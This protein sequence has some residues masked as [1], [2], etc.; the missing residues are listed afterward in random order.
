MTVAITPPPEK[1]SVKGRGLKR[2]LILIAAACALFLGLVFLS[3]WTQTGSRLVLMLVTEVSPGRLQFN[4]VEGRLADHLRIK[5]LDYESK[6]LVVH[7]QDV[8][9]DWSISSLFSSALQIDVLKAAALQIHVT[10]DDTPA[11]LPVHLQAPFAF[12]VK[13]LMITQ[14]SLFIVE[15]AAKASPPL[16]FEKLHG[17]V[18][19][20]SDQYQAT[21]AFA[22]EWGQLSG[23][24]KLASQ[25]PFALDANVDYQNRAQEELP[26][27]HLVGHARGT[28]DHFQFSVKS[29]EEILTNNVP[30]TDAKSNS[31]QTKEM[32]ILSSAQ[33]QLALEVHLFSAH[34]LQKL[35]TH[36]R[37]FDPHLLAANAPHALLDLDLKLQQEE[38]DRLLHLSGVLQMRNAKAASLD[39]NGLP[40]S[41]LSAQLVWRNQKL[42]LTDFSAELG[43]QSSKKNGQESALGKIGGKMSADFS[44]D[45]FPQVEAHFDVRHLNLATIDSRVRHTDVEGQVQIQNQGKSRIEFQAKLQ[46]SRTRLLTRAHI[47][48]QTVG[49]GARLFLDQFELSADQSTLTG[50]AQ[51]ELN[52]THR[53]KLNGKLTHFNPAQWFALP[54]G[55]VDAELSIEGQSDPAWQLQV[56]V[57]SLSGVWQGR[58][59]EG[60]LHSQWKEA[61]SLKFEQTALHLG[62][63]HLEMQGQLGDGEDILKLHFKGNDLT[64]LTA[65]TGFPV[66]GSAEIDASLKGK[67]SAFESDLHLAAENLVFSNGRRLA[68]AQGQITLGAG[69]QGVL[70]LK[71]KLA[72]LQ[73]DLTPAATTSIS[74]ASE[75]NTAKLRTYFESAQ[76]EVGGT[77]D[78]HQIHSEIQFDRQHQ[79]SLD[80][81]G[82]ILGAA[83]QDLGWKGRVTQ[84]NLHGFL[85][86]DRQTSANAKVEPDLRLESPFE[87]NIH[88]QAV[89]MG[90]AVLQGRLGKL[91]LKQLEWTPQNLSSQGQFD[92]L[93]ALALLSLWKPQP[94]LVGDL[95]LGLT[96]DFQ[97]KEHL[98]AALNLQRQGGDIG[99]RDVDGTGKTMPLGIE[100][101]HLQL[102]SQAQTGK[103]NAERVAVDLN[104]SGQRLGTWQAHLQSEIRKGQDRWIL[105]AQT[106]IQGEMQVHLPE[107]Q[108]LASQISPEFT[109]KGSVDVNAQLGGQLF[110]P[111]Y[112][113]QIEGHRLEL[114]FAS[115]GLLFPN[116]E[117]KAALT[118]DTLSLQKLVF[119]QTITRPVEHERFKDLSWSQSQTQTQA[120]SQSQ[121]QG[122]FSASG[123][124]NWRAQSGGITAQWTQF[125]L[126]QRRDRWLVMSGQAKIAQQDKAWALTGNL[127]ADAGF[128]R[129]P[130]LPPPSLS[131]DVVIASAKTSESDEEQSVDKVGLKTRLDLTVDM[132]SRFI[133]VGRGLNTAL[134]GSLRLK[135]SDGKSVIA[136]GRIATDGGV[137]EGYGQQLSIERGILDFHGAANNPSLNIRALRKGLQVEAGVDII[138]SVANPQ[139]RLVSEPN[140]PDN[141]KISWLVF[142]RESEQNGSTDI[143]ALL[144][145]AG[146]ILGGDG[147]RE[148]SATWVR[149]LGFDSLTVGPPE[150]GLFSK[151]PSQTV[152]GAISV[153]AS[154]NENVVTGRLHVKPGL[155]LS[156]ER[157]VSDASN[158]LSLSWQWSRRLRLVG[159]K[160][161][162]NALDVRYSFS[163]N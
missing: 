145:A 107:L 69:S 41:Q 117:L 111:K 64:A 22:S 114:A 13:Q 98:R 137:Y 83:W 157:G 139:V 58:N 160:G 9:L 71:L 138:G 56:N 82:G 75:G 144:S 90:A 93:Q 123:D 97:F 60:Q 5:N 155:V 136:N 43:A 32:R 30:V 102:T 113:A 134:S 101:L 163:F 63:N 68:H 62:D 95:R 106:P 66:N 61:R 49:G 140:V 51:V 19:A 12:N 55:R 141:E 14:T 122:Q 147:S 28:L 119:T 8:Q 109:M 103:P 25:R 45:Q 100:T 59:L 116:G 53:F 158:A 105:D 143:S 50:Q 65:Q 81:V 34:V 88:R 20:S 161:N 142:G 126:L 86:Q 36:M 16:R 29:A 115:E 35:E 99:V 92:D 124:V 15:K 38:R 125:P 37:Q 10:Q 44:K 150:H 77:R 17:S 73:S 18:V 152:A 87:L 127:R 149:G 104:A 79:L 89:V 76:I 148:S 46:D 2:G 154:A 57:T 48:L 121:S 21:L 78:A 27:L 24:A 39:Q 42:D 118:E 120:Q 162:D 84:L 26:A 1:A 52:D 159:R 3:V 40:L 112:K 7:A 110:K 70:A 94:T 108:W 31:A 6:K 74:T 23:H 153:G 132:G 33:A 156:V 47:D 11:Q 4:G 80:A 130:K 151:L 54:V 131:D 91:S 135:S 146:A 128:F 129:L 133:F 96:W 72:Q 67:L 85:A